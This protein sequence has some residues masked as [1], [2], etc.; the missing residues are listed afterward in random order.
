MGFSARD[1][2][3]FFAGGCSICDCSDS[4]PCTDASRSR[5]RIAARSAHPSIWSRSEACTRLSRAIIELRYHG[6][7]EHISIRRPRMLVR[8]RRTSRRIVNSENRNIS[9]SLTSERL[10]RQNVNIACRCRTGSGR[11]ACDP[12]CSDCNKNKS[13]TND[14]C[15]VPHRSESPKGYMSTAMIVARPSSALLGV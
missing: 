10:L 6:A 4:S 8:R 11:G 5:T 3:R 1:F 15:A 7:L 12:Q 9:A 14:R 13:R 2:Y